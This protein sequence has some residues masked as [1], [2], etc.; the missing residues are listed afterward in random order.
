MDGTFDL[1]VA[2]RGWAHG[3]D[4]RIKLL[5]VLTGLISMTLFSNLFFLL[6]ALLGIHILIASAGVPRERFIW[7][8]RA[9]LPVTLLLPAL[10]TL[11]YPEGEAI[12][13]PG[14]LRLTPLALVR[15]LSVAARLDTMAFICF[16]WLFTTDQRAIVRSLVRLG[17][18]FEWGLVLAISLRHLST[19][20]NLYQMIT[21]AQQARALDLSGRSWFQRLRAQLPILVAMVINSLRI[22]DKLTLALESRAFGLEGVQ[23]TCLHDIRC[24]HRDYILG[25]AILSGFCGFIWLRVLGLFTHPLYLMRVACH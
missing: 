2:R 21:E 8:W 17:L 23:R 4:P 19:F 7:A 13:E 14:V 3:V 9:M 25:V 20:Y 22:A 15:G 12:F 11:F 1:Y 16:F 24:T 6:V 18:P 5:F 10:W